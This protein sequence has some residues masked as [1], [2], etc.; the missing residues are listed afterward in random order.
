MPLVS[1]DYG[2]LCPTGC[3]GFAHTKEGSHNSYGKSAPWVRRT[4][5]CGRCGCEIETQ[6]VV[7]SFVRPLFPIDRSEVDVIPELATN[8]D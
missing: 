8:C 3:G 7:V 1:P 5:V 4:K 6:E 2:M